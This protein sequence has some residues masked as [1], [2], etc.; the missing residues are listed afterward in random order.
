M[1]GPLTFV[2][3]AALVCSGC[4]QTRQSLEPPNLAAQ[5][6]EVDLTVER[7]QRIGATVD[8]ELGQLRQLSADFFG[9]ASGTWDHPFPLDSFKHTAMSCLNAPYNQEPP[10]PSVSEAADRLGVTCAVPAALDLEHHLD[11]TPAQRSI[12]LAKLAQVDQLRSVRS[13]L[14]SRLRQLPSILR[15]ARAYLSTRRAEARQMIKDAQARQTDYSRKSFDEAMHRIE[16][17]EGRL[18][19]LD[20]QLTELEDASGRW[21]KQLGEIVDA[22]YKDLSRLGRS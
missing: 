13:K 12:A 17:Y 7:L 20:H 5:N 10:E 9:A 16:A 8:D 3:L 4:W 19:A 15:R 21:S 18:T 22:L 2:F 1:R 14:Q 11:E 6:E